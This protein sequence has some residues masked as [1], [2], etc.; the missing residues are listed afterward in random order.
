MLPIIAIALILTGILLSIAAGIFRDWLKDKFPKKWYYRIG[1]ILLPIAIGI[2]I[3]FNYKSKKGDS[4]V[5]NISNKQIKPVFDS[6]DTRFKILI[7]PFNK[8]CTYEGGKYDIGLVIKNRMDSLN[9]NDSLSL[10]IFYLYTSKDLDLIN[11]TSKTADSLIEFNNANL[12]IYGDYTLKECGTSDKICFN[13]QTDSSKSYLN[14]KKF[15][16]DAY[17]R[18][19]FKGTESLSKGT[20]QENIDFVIYYITAMTV[21]T[22]KE[23]EKAIK[24][25]MK[26][27]NFERNSTILFNI[28]M[29]HFFQGEYLNAVEYLKKSLAIQPK[30]VN[31]WINLGICYTPKQQTKIKIKLPV[32]TFSVKATRNPLVNYQKAKYCFEKALEINPN[33][34]TALSNLAVSYDQLGNFSKAKETFKK[35]IQINPNYFLHWTLLGQ[36]YIH[37][38]EFSKAKEALEK[39]ISLDSSYWLIYHNLGLIYLSTNEFELAKLN[40]LKSIKK[41]PDNWI[42][43]LHLGDMYFLKL[44]NP[45]EALRCFQK[46]AEIDSNNPTILNRYGDFFLETKNYQ[47]SKFYLEKSIELDPND[48]KTFM[49]LSLACHSLGDNIKAI[50][51]I[52]K[53]IRLDPN[54]YLGYL[55]LGHYYLE[56]DENKALTNF[57]MAIAKDTSKY[58]AFYKI[59]TSYGEKKQKKSS[60]FYLSKAIENNIEVKKYAQSELLFK[61]LWAD[62]D[63]IHLTQ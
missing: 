62:P 47:L 37:S 55:N 18:S 32:D 27:N 6:A 33:N 17:M 22:H 44:N 2:S 28:G 43:W 10:N 61:W 38:K 56:E 40:Y 20:G 59:A 23:F 36:V 9:Q 21:T 63:F 52:K 30:D 57:K 15:N 49:N 26:I 39:A 54:N 35:A 12:L 41:Y 51:Y 60:L 5:S 1:I 3:L 7:L 8:I 53:S 25:Y 24:L 19:F 31:T 58:W 42:A 45:I 46:A 50:E 11:F 16:D 14:E 48:S 29:T 34:D 13:Y 4:I